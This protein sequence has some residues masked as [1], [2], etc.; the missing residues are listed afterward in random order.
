M[1]KLKRFNYGAIVLLFIAGLLA[2]GCNI[3]HAAEIADIKLTKGMLPDGWRLLEEVS[4][5]EKDLA[6][7]GGRFG[8]SIK[9][10]INQTFAVNSIVIQVNY[11]LPAVKEEAGQLY[12]RLNTMVGGSNDVLLK[13]DVVIEIISQDSHLRSQVAE[14]LLAGDIHK[15]KLKVKALPEDWSLVKEIIVA[16]AHLS[17][18]EDVYGVKV[19]GIINQIFN[20]QGS[21]VQINYVSAK[22]EAG[23]D[24]IYQKMNELAGGSNTIIK[25]GKTTI[26]IISPYIKFTNTALKL[27]LE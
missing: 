13:K 8:L 15:E 17:Q 22:D 4:V 6:A 24:K 2:S 9:E 23:A 21:R 18:F 27:L 16:E 10:I 3:C 14:L 1:T 25:R 11:S 5:P 19:A 20:V 26:E 7:F 12:Q